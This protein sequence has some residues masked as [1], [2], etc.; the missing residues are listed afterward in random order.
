MTMR[1]FTQKAAAIRLLLTDCDGVLTDGTV[2]YSAQREEMK[3]F[4]L[5][6]GMGV[7]RL[8]RLAGVEVGIITGEC[9]AAVQQRA[10]KLGIVE[11]HEGIKDKAAV[12]Q[13]ILRR[14]GL[15]CEQVAYIGDDTN[16]LNIM[17]KV[18]LTACPADALPMVLQVV[19]VVCGR[20]GGEGAFREFAELIIEAKQTWSLGHR[21]HG[22]DTEIHREAIRVNS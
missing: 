19:D 12:L 22:E 18:G 17:S 2:Y 6:D 1:S 3:R 16:D 11:L 8:R 21:G 15:R 7:E 4:N 9:S 14:H 20:K 13:A 10:A 5:R